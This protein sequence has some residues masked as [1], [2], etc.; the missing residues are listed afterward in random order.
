MQ[1]FVVE[2][3]TSTEFCHRVDS[4]ARRPHYL[5][6]PRHAL[7]LRFSHRS[8]PSFRARLISVKHPPFRQSYNTRH[9]ARPP[10]VL[11]RKLAAGAVVH[12]LRQTVLCQ[13]ISPKLDAFFLHKPVEQ[14]FTT[15]IANVHHGASRVNQSLVFDFEHLQ[16]SFPLTLDQ[17]PR[18]PSSQSSHGG[19]FLGGRT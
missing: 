12:H 10:W 5:P 16:S 4:F 11:K 1:T 19:S 13:S 15:G 18:P 6:H 3:I 17:P 7:L 2:H 9:H 8:F 14:I